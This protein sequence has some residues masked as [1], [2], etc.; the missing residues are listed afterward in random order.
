MKRFLVAMMLVMGMIGAATGP[1]RAERGGRVDDRGSGDLSV[2]AE[3]LAAL[4]SLAQACTPAPIGVDPA[5]ADQRLADALFGLAAS[6]DSIPAGDT[7]A[8]AAVV[9]AKARLLGP[10]VARRLRAAQLPSEGPVAAAFD[11]LAEETRRWIERE[12]HAGGDGPDSR[13]FMNY[14]RCLVWCSEL[15]T[16]ALRAACGIDCDMDFAA[17]TLDLVRDVLDVLRRPRPEEEI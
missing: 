3:A 15:E 10:E 4:E 11:T 12:T 7:R 13:C 17:C 8:F 6:L 2:P 9:S 1:A 5:A 16:F 14:A